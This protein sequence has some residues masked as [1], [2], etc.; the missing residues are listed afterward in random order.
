MPHK[1]NPFALSFV[2]AA[3]NRLIGVQ[4]GIAAAGRTPSGQMDNRLFVY[5]AAPD[6]VRLAGEIALLIAECVEGLTF[7]ETRALAALDDRSA[8]ASDLVERLMAAAGID[9]RAAHGVVGGLV[10]ALEE[11]GRTLAK[12]T[13]DDLRTAL[14][15]AN[16]PSACV[17][18]GLIASA[19]NPSACV[20]ARTDVG[21]A[22][23]EEVTAM[24]DALVAAIGEHRNRVED[25]QAHREAALRRLLAEA[26]KFLKDT[27]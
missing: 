21:G 19:L 7:G 2:R 12:A 17:T 15:T 25:A 13:A 24:A 10:Q 23:P 8:C 27:S 5:E 18:E 22:A 11:N 14:H 4:A 26:E 20:A 1:R 9:Y 3:A 6:A 16:L